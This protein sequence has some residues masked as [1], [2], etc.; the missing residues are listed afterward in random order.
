MRLRKARITVADLEPGRLLSDA[1]TDAVL[2][3]VEPRT[4]CRTEPKVCGCGQPLTLPQHWREHMAAA[5]HRVAALFVA[6]GG[7]Y[8]GLDDVDP[9]DAARDARLYAGPHPVVAHPPCER[10]G[11]YATAKGATAGDD[12]GC[13]AAALAAVRQWGVRVGALRPPSAQ[14]HLALCR[15]LRAAVT[16]PKVLLTHDSADTCNQEV[17]DWL[18]RWCH[19][20]PSRFGKSSAP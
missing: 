4:L 6:A 2:Q 14:S 13:F 16:G 11:R 1:E 8:F 17:E 5:R 20:H 19:E 18:Q 10:W 7:C 9:W 12:G 15:R 3:R